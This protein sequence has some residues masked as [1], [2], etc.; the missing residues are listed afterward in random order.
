MAVSTALAPEAP[1]RMGESV[2]PAAML[3]YLEALGAWRAARRREL[4]ELDRLALAS[5]HGAELAGDVTL[6]MALWQAVS[7]RYEELLRVWDSGRVGAVERQQLA[8]LVWGRIPSAG[9][10]SATSLAVSLPEACRLSDA[11]AGQLRMRLSLDPL[12]LDL[13]ERL[14]AMRATLERVRDLVATSPAGPA[15]EAA[16]GRLDGLARRLGDVTERAQRGADVG[17]LVGP[18]EAD[19]ATTERDLI[20]A[21]ATKRDE[22]R[23]RRRAAALRD[24]LLA[25]ATAL[26]AVVEECVARVTPAPTLAIPRVEA[27]GAVPEE[28]REVDAYLARLGAVARALAQA[29][30][31]YRAPLAELDRLR[32]RLELYRA[33]ATGRGLVARPEVAELYRLARAVLLETPADLPRARAV[34]SA[35]QALLGE[36]RIT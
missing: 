3:R 21:A 26:S 15:R 8:A 7:V 16:A 31:A 17:G 20:V 22:E 11:L 9:G 18:W 35:Y 6:S 1:S 30:E 5:P 2:E 12:G 19:A 32:A 24:E 13:A 29:E 36:G 25:R 14:R 28:P 10:P 33:T 4:D 34:V 23:A 27:L